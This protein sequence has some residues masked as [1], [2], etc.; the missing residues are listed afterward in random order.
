MKRF[1]AA[2]ALLL[3]LMIVAGSVTPRG[4]TASP[5]L[6]TDPA[7]AGQWAGPFDWP[8]I[9]V[10]SV[11]MPTGRTLLFSY[12]DS[13]QVWDP[14][15]N[16]FVSS[17]A[18]TRDLFCG[19]QSLMPDGRVL[20]TGGTV[21]GLPPGLPKGL[22]DTH[23]F[24]PFTE[25]WERVGDMAQGRWY[26]TNLT[27][28]D[29]RT[30]VYSGL[31][32]TGIVTWNVEVYESGVGWSQIGSI[33]ALPLYPNIH[34]LSTGLAYYSGPTRHTSYITLVPPGMI[35]DQTS[36]YGLRN[37]GVNILL[38]PGPDR[39]MILGGTRDSVPTATVEIIDLTVDSP[40]WQYTTPMNFARED[41]NAVI[42]P[43]AT[44]FVIGG[45]EFRPVEGQAPESTAVFQPEIYDPET[46][47][48]SLMA[49][50]AI[51]RVYHST[52]VLLPDGRILAGGTD[53]YYFGGDLF[54][55]IS[56]R[57]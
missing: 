54:T 17:E 25:S 47:T 8:L 46:A 40:S 34:L 43:D 33:F 21:R 4:L 5:E 48:W 3:P 18:L 6:N 9:S 11:V 28:P 22:R 50:M 26:P 13:T 45:H 49:E 32:D 29:G 39:I 37:G 38:P 30:Y 44:V 52:A 14:V 42:L 15:S 1:S 2:L 12:D 31:D 7:T 24:D 19:G 57:R 27:G 56:L 53:G 55:S 36:N 16:G 10:H 41:A 20:V 51:P 23:I 35:A